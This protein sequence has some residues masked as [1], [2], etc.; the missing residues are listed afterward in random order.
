[1]E[2]L[3]IPPGY[4]QV[5][6]YL[7]VNGAADFINWTQQIFG[8]KEKMRH[9]RDEHIIAHAE[10]TIGDCVI[11]LADATEA[12]PARN[13]GF[14]I[15]MADAD[16]VYNKAI[17]AGAIVVSPMADMPYGRSGGVTDPFGNTWWITCQM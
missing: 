9:M 7:I 15:Y 13:V 8:A 17:N 3:K 14:F 16:A 2:Q 1:M 12:F 4:Q 5:M 6:V 10:I 11:M